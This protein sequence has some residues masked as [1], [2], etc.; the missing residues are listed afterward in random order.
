[1]YWMQGAEERRLRRMSNTPQGGAIEGNAADDALMVD[2][3]LDAGWTPVGLSDS[4]PAQDERVFCLTA[5]TRR[6]TQ[7]K[8]LFC[9]ADPPA[10]P[11]RSQPVRLG[12][13]L[14][15]PGGWRAGLPNKTLH[16]AD[17]GKRSHLLYV[18]RTRSEFLGSDVFARSEASGFLLFSTSRGFE[19]HHRCECVT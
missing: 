15:V 3:G 14:A 17:A 16:P 4:M 5:D 19:N 7:T 2:Q 8:S 11:E 9:S 18:L 10:S 6:Q 12:Q 13:S 1:M